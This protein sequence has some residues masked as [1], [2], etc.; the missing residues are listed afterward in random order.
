MAPRFSKSSATTLLSRSMPDSLSLRGAL[1]PGLESG[2]PAGVLRPFLSRPACLC[3]PCVDVA[4]FLHRWRSGMFLSNHSTNRLPLL[5]APCSP[6]SANRMLRS[7]ITAAARRVLAALEVS[8]V[9][10][11]LMRGFGGASERLR[12]DVLF[13]TFQKYQHEAAKF[14]DAEAAFVKIFQLE[15]LADRRWWAQLIEDE[16]AVHEA[17]WPVVQSINFC[18]K[19]MPSIVHLLERDVDLPNI[20]QVDGGN[21]LQS[22]SGLGEERGAF[23]SP[24]RL[25]KALE[26]MQ[27][28]YDACARIHHENENELS[29]ISMDSGSDKSFDCMGAAKVVEEIRR[30]I[31]DLWD[32]VVFFRERKFEQ[33]I[34]LI[35]G[36]LPV[37]ERIDDLGRNGSVSREECEIIKRKIIDGVS[38][39]LE[40]GAMLPEFAGEASHNPRS[41][42][43][44][45]R[46]C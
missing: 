10:D 20:R 39:F 32:R 40:T 45:S 21:G 30:I 46:S 25:V 13:A 4:N 12:P 17:V 1:L 42:L 23:S 29:V 15:P 8:G 24:Q 11:L 16:R 43:T 31:L 41:L 36:T 5:Y 37:L 2:L 26:S 7:E 9:A 22:L 27:K 6:Y 28:M 33:R 19:Y 35:S 38:L 44:L 3:Q 18:R 14:S 34:E